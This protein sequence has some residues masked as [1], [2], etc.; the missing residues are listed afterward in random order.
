MQV[1]IPGY[2]TK[3]PTNAWVMDEEGIAV[4]RFAGSKHIEGKPWD[5]TFNTDA[6]TTADLPDGWYYGLEIH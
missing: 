3:A 1:T 2:G 4:H 6:N 5:V